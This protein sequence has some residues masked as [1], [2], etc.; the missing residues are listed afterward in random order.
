MC[1]FDFTVVSE[2]HFCWQINCISLHFRKRNSSTLPPHPLSSCPTRAYLEKVWPF[3]NWEKLLLVKVIP[4]PQGSHHLIL[5][6]LHPQN[7]AFTW[8]LMRLQKHQCF[9]CY[10]E[11]IFKKP[12]H[13]ARQLTIGDQNICWDMTSF[14][15]KHT[16]LRTRKCQKKDLYIHSFC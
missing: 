8:K 13:A 4:E 10:K 12:M 14:T 11:T 5:I 9:K 3:P 16:Q 7:L 6:L 15:R 1:W 2:S